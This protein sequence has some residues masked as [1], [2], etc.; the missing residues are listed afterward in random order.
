MPIHHLN[1][2]LAPKSVVVIGA[3]RASGSGGAAVVRNLQAFG[4]EVFFVDALAD[5]VDGAKC[6]RSV[7]ELPRPVDLAVVC[8][9][10]EAVADVVRQCGTAGIGGIVILST[11]FHEASPLGTKLEAD[12]R[13]A[14]LPFKSLRVV[15]P[16]CLGIL[17]P[18]RSLNA[19]LVSSAPVQGRV[20]FISQS[21]GLCASV[22]DWAVKENVGFSHIV[23][24]GNMIDVQIAD[25]LDYFALDPWTEAVV[26]Y[27]ESIR[28]ARSFLSAARAFARAKPMI[29]Y[30]AG[31]FTT[32]ARGVHQASAE[33]KRGSDEAFTAAFRRAGVVRVFEGDELFDIAQLLA[34]HPTP[35]GSR[36]AILTNAGALG[37]MAAD[38]LLEQQGQLAVFSSETVQQLQA[39]LPDALSAATWSQGNPFDIAGDASPDRY[40]TAVRTVLADP[41][42]DGVLVILAPQWQTDPN[43]SAAAVISAAQSTKKPVLASWIGGQRVQ[44]G[45]EQL[46]RAGIPTYRSP[47]QAVRAF[48]HLANYGRCRETLFETPADLPLRL[49]ADRDETKR[50]LL[51]MPY[52]GPRTLSEPESR[53][54]LA[55]YGLTV[56]EISRRVPESVDRLGSVSSPWLVGSQ[57]DAVFGTL[58]FVSQRDGGAR[59]GDTFGRID[60]RHS[61]RVFE[62]PPIDD[63]LARRMLTALPTW[64]S[65]DGSVADRETLAAQT[66][67][68]LLRLSALVTECPEVVTVELR[69]DCRPSS[70]LLVTDVRVVVDRV[71]VSPAGR[72][73]AHLAIR[74][75]P[76][77]LIR[78]LQLS[79][80]TAVVLR[81]IKPEDEPLWHTL[82][83]NCSL[84]TI[85][86][87]FRYMF[88]ATTHEMATRFCY[89]DYDRELA[90]VAELVEQGQR[91]IAGVARLVA[92][93][94]HREAEYAILVGDPWQGRGL[95]SLLTDH[96]FGICEQ[97]NLQSIVAEMAP[98][99]L[100]MIHMFQK[101]G[102]QL[103]RKLSD[104]V[105]IA[106]KPLRSE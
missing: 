61:N 4:G 103:N 41:A 47:E 31:R 39:E 73:I 29:A 3:G 9:P 53:S 95:G 59:G 32:S 62:L 81:P 60:A 13:G 5:S 94:D 42:V 35:S 83:A 63:R 37:V 58:L 80:G 8:S 34:K 96:C 92:D 36:L 77:E 55:A 102:F 11:G 27:L 99:N 16:N 70:G 38:A 85:Q 97:W 10:A 30:K 90:I 65:A 91:K 66:G 44:A 18:H 89:L 71:T 88:K 21:A 84:E 17:V 57:R 48:L 46:Q 52:T 7:K 1:K 78:H 40:A 104:D 25:L 75:Y 49:P 43:A 87:R 106:R 2:I 69:P 98:R 45:S 56:A 22:L 76:T 64:S 105:V 86:M 54:L 23:S 26:V 12:V 79:D 100:R 68:I 19:S 33:P 20:A 74:P 24:V 6:Y 67:D 28:D 101:R 93:A 50:A 51:A 82:L 15:G 14:A 72:K